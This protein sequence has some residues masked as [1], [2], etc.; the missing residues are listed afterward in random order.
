MLDNS[1]LATS[2]LPDNAHDFQVSSCLQKNFVKDKSCYARSFTV[3]SRVA[4]LPIF[5][6][7]FPG[8]LVKPTFPFEVPQLKGAY[9]RHQDYDDNKPVGILGCWKS[10]D[11]H[12]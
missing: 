10:S 4:A 3:V 7:V 11:I 1:V 5:R 8:L 9:G 6:A 2:D 12:A